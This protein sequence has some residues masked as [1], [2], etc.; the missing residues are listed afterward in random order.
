PAGIERQ[1]VLFEHPLE[2]PDGAGLILKD[3]PVVRDVAADGAKA[4]LLVKRAGPVNVLDGEADG[5][6]A[7]THTLFP[8]SKWIDTTRG[9]MVPEPPGRD[10]QILRISKRTRQAT[11]L[12]YIQRV[13]LAIDH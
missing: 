5:E 2:E 4:E 3:Q 7:Q 10:C 6:V 12:T 9:C 1:A 11:A 13:N 8:W